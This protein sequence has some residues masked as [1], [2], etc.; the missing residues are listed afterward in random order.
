MHCRRLSA[1]A[2]HGSGHSIEVRTRM[3]IKR[4]E[5]IVIAVGMNRKSIESLKAA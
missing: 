4:R 1:G 5:L 2:L 3:R